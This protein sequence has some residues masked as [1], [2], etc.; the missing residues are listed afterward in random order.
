MI[1]GGPCC[2]DRVVK[3]LRERGIPTYVVDRRTTG[4]NLQVISTLEE[5]ER[6]AH[7]SQLE[8]QPAGV[9]GL[10]VRYPRRC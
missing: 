3:A 1:N 7:F 10:S 6:H 8:H 4:E 5:N 9:E 2:W